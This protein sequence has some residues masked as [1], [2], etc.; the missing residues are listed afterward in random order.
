MVDGIIL[1]CV[2]FRAG[3]GIGVL[4]IV[5]GQIRDTKI[6]QAQLPGIDN[7]Y[8]VWRWRCC[9]RSGH[10]QLRAVDRLYNPAFHNA[11]LGA[12]H[13]CVTRDS[14]GT[15]IGCYRFKP[16]VIVREA[17]TINTPGNALISEGK[18][19][20]R[21]IGEAIQPGLQRNDTVQ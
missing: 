8:G 5:E 14:A 1:R 19:G 11:A 9:E 16:G 6:L 4:F 3:N 20:A 17:A 12:D 2:V 15:A 18:Y 21:D 10:D 13:Q 7:E